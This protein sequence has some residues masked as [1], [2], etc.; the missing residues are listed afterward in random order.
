MTVS[1]PSMRRAKVEHKK[2]TTQNPEVYVVEDATE[3]PHPEVDIVAAN[4][5][6]MQAQKPEEPKDI[7]EKTSLIEDLLFLGCVK[8]E[9]TIG[10]L[11]FEIS[12]LTQGESAE[13][14]KE[15]Y[16]TESGADLFAVR[17]LTLAYAIKSI[18]D[19]EFGEVPLGSTQEEAQF[20]TARAKKVA[21]IGK[22]QKSVVEKLHEE[23]I[24]LVEKSE[25]TLDDAGEE[26]KN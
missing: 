20:E 15:L 19:V 6:A 11:K 8:K 2:E 16:K 25:S 1:H 9:I 4:E 18:N 12:T 7:G 24:E 21:I 17:A 14:M 10:K 13:L 5:Q 3:Q 26:L 23:Y 22:M